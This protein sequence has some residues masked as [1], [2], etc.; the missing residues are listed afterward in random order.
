MES[1]SYPIKKFTLREV[2]QKLEE[3]EPQQLI[4]YYV[5]R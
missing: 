3:Q 4:T 1:A 2:F 5:R